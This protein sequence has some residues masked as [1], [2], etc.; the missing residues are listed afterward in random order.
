LGADRYVL[1]IVMHHIAGD[2]M[3][4]APLARDLA[5]AYA[6]RLE[7]RA[8]GWAPLPIQYADYTLWQREVLGSETETDSEIARQLEYW[9]TTLAGLPEELRLP[10]DRPRP[11][12]ASH[13]GATV[14]FAVPAELHRRMAELA[15]RT[16]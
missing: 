10:T 8:P 14:P 3:S 1:L 11:P 16:R 7:G 4:M 2:G 15:R 13:K 5:E 6:A 12:V 9:R